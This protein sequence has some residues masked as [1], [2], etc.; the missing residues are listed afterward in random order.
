MKKGMS[1]KC[2]ISLFIN[3]TVRLLR[4]RLP[5]YDT[6]QSYNPAIHRIKQ[7]L[8]HGVIT[9]DLSKNPLP[10]PHPELLK[11]FNP[12]ERVLKRARDAVDE[13][14]KHFKIKPGLFSSSFRFFEGHF[15]LI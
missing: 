9:S 14:R 8:F 6:V 11:Y 4:N 12:P 5:W 2:G 13:C 7:A 3:I 1:F 15:Q 10:P